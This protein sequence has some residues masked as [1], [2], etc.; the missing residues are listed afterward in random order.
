MEIAMLTLNTDTLRRALQIQEKIEALQQEQSKLLGGKVTL[1]TLG[2]AGVLP[3]ARRGRPR[4]SPGRPKGSTVKTPK[5]PKTPGRKRKSPLAGKKRAASPSG[6]LADAVL[7]VLERSH[8]PLGVDGIL[9]GL[10]H[11]NYIW[12]VADPKK[13][14]AARVYKLRGVK[15][16]G[17]G[18][19]DLASRHGG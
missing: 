3:T 15:Q 19:F 4:K 11:D 10:Q 8:E 5:T 13:N 2:A 17:P 14:L 7:R 1:A 18:R 16:V 12:T 6:P 9:Q